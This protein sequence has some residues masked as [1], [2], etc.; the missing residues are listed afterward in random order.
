MVRSIDVVQSA[1]RRSTRS[2][3]ETCASDAVP[4][5]KIESAI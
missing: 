1:S 4:E 5:S 2:V 3:S